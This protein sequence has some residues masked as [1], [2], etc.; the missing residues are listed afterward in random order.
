MP[1]QV[2]RRG[3]FPPA[4][5]ELQ[6]NSQPVLCRDHPD[7]HPQS[8]LVTLA[9]REYHQLEGREVQL[10]QLIEEQYAANMQRFAGRAVDERAETH[11]QV[12]AGCRRAGRC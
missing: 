12:G 9:L 3:H 11:L 4:C 1:E 6:C 2:R 5:C 8:Y 7:T 10:Q